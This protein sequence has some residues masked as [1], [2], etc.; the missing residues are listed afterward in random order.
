MKA[1]MRCKMCGADVELKWEDWTH[2]NG[3]SPAALM[4]EDYGEIPGNWRERN[5]E[6]WSWTC[7][8][9]PH[10]KWHDC[11]EGQLGACEW[12]GIVR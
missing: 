5:L 2:C 7:G 4:E 3:R 1:L 8:I 9:S 10:Q 6:L 12:I 11:K